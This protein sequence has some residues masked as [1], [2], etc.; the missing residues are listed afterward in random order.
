MRKERER[1]KS[2]RVIVEGGY[3]DDWRTYNSSVI[4]KVVPPS[5]TRISCISGSYVL[6]LVGEWGNGDLQWFD[7][8]SA[9]GEAIE[10]SITDVGLLRPRTL[11]TEDG[12]IFHDVTLLESEGEIE[13]KRLVHYLEILK[14]KYGET[15]QE[16]ISTLLQK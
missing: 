6:T 7:Q 1:E 4:E 16:I 12:R 9:N 14:K 5:C 8:I 10:L 15:P 13:Q 2:S 11:I 3:Q